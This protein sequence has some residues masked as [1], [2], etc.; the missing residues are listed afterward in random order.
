MVTQARIDANRQNAK[1]S[2]GPRTPSGKA[3]ASMNAVKHGLSSRKPLIPG[4]D[5]AEFAQFTSE[6]VHQLRP[7]GPRERLAAEQAI[8]AAWRLRRVPQIEAGLLALQMRMD[9]ER[10]RPVHPFAMS[11]EAYQELSRLDRHQAAL[12][13]TLDRSLK[14]LERLQAER[15]EDETADY[16]DEQNE[17]NGAEGLLMEGVTDT[18]R[19]HEKPIDGG[20]SG[21]TGLRPA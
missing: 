21:P 18:I 19:S 13:R 8:M 14:E 7:F 4:E 9:S 5:E 16:A 2:T 10:M 6:W 1:K 11:S 17:A 12:E 15:G 3:I 20:L